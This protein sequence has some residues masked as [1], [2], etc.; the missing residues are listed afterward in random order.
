MLLTPA[1][2]PAKL[3]RRKATVPLATASITKPFAPSVFVWITGGVAASGAASIVTGFVISTLS[4]VNVPLHNSIFPPGGTATR[5]SPKLVKVVRLPTAPAG[6]RPTTGAAPTAVNVSGL[7]IAPIAVAMTRFTPSAAPSV[8]VPTE[9]SPSEPVTTEFCAIVPPPSTV[10][11]TVTPATPLWAAVVSRSSTVGGERT[12]VPTAPSCG[13]IEFVT[14]SGTNDQVNVLYDP[15]LPPTPRCDA[16]SGRGV[17]AR[18]KR[19]RNPFTPEPRHPTD[20]SPLHGRNLAGTFCSARTG[21]PTSNWNSWSWRT[22]VLGT[23]SRSTH[24]ATMTGTLNWVGPGSVKR[25]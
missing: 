21:N 23:D 9:A 16:N 24:I 3:K 2:V 6:H 22:A 7:P 20:D 4:A 13:L 19:A 8:H 14:I 5:A 10:N 18:H 17:T 11:V 12:G 15:A 1:P 25:S